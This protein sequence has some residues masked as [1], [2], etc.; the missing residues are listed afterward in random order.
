MHRILISAPHSG[1]GKTT[2]TIGLI[3]ALRRRGLKVAPFKVGPDY[4]DTAYHQRAAGAYASNLDAF[5][6]PEESLRAA[7]ARRARGADIAVAEGV[8]GLFD[9]IGATREA[10][11][12]SVAALLQM[13]VLLVVNGRGMAASAAALVNGF[14]SH[15]PSVSIAGVVFND[16]SESHYSILRGAVENEAGVKCLGYLPNSEDIAIKSR[17]L[18]IL[19][20]GEVMD[21]ER[22]IGRMAD[23]VGETVDVDAIVAI[24]AQAPPLAV[25]I[26][27]SYKQ[28]PC[29]LAVA[30]DAA[31]NFYYEDSLDTLRA[32]GAE[33][34]FFSP[35][36]DGGLPRCGG[37]YIGGGFPE[38]FAKR[39]AEN[40]ALR[41]AIR[42][43]S[44]AGMPV[45]GECGGYLYLSESIRVDGE[46]FAMCGALP[47][48]A[49]MGDR[50]SGQFGYVRVA[51][52][53]DT[54]LGRAGSVYR[55]H[56]FHHSA[57]SGETEAYVAEKASGGRKWSGG[58]VSRNTFGAYAHV[59]FAGEPG[60]AENFLEACE[61]F[62]AG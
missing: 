1:S 3:G 20:E 22:R 32:M 24:A 50:L 19:P 23:L 7:F 39:L 53:A 2:F 29:T 54:P 47:V 44:L 55:A 36:N 52:K 40:R 9:G 25:P 30:R 11:T 62:E 26:S 35:L 59:N 45:Y 38:V 12:A 57:M 4:I 37:V 60:L 61:R 51:L 16:V 34:A 27:A 17:Q 21:A 6:L 42:G 41:D 13:P 56:E 46:D 58:T 5:L 43:V 28:R 10:S 31:F 33:L 18:G 14:A 49:A 15:D 8:M 48:A